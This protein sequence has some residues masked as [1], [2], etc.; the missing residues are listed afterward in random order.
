MTTVAPASHTEDRTVSVGPLESPHARAMAA[1]LASD[2]TVSSYPE[3]GR[4]LATAR[5][6]DGENRVEATVVES[7]G[8]VG[9]WTM[10]LSASEAI[11]AGTIRV[12][13]GEIESI[14]VTS[15]TFK[16]KGTSGERIAFTF[17]KK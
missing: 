6:K 2:G 3:R 10:D 4:T 1:V 11:Q 8:K 13:A 12:L 15:V 16:L 14:G 17:L 7:A 9:R 5:L